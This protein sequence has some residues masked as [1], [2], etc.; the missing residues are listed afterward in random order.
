MPLPHALK[1]MARCHGDVQLCD[2]IL[3]Q[4]TRD[5]SGFLRHRSRTKWVQAVCH[6]KLKDLCG[7]QQSTHAFAATAL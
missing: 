7:S 6:V 3:S 1:L 5:A 4:E 2:V